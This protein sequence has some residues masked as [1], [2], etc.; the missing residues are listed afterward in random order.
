MDV[1]LPDGTIITNVPDGTTKADLQAKLALKGMKAD[2]ANFEQQN[3]VDPAQAALIGAGRTGDKA[4]AGAKQIGLSA[5]V[6][7]RDLVGADTKAPL[8]SLAMLDAIQKGNDTEYR[9]LQQQFP[10]ST[11]LGEAFPTLA[12]PMGQ[13]TTLGRVMAPAI[14]TGAIEAMQ[15]GSPLERFQR[16]VGGF[17]AGLTGGGIG[18][19]IG[20]V[21]QPVRQVGNTVAQDAAKAAAAKIGAPLL[22]SQQT[23]NPTLALIE[24]SLARAPGSAGVIGGVLR[25]QQSAVNSAAARAIQ[26]PGDAVTQSVVD[27]AMGNPAA[28]VTGA[29]P[30]QYDAFRAQIPNG[31]P[32]VSDVF[33][34]IDKGIASLSRGDRQAAGKPEAI[35]MLTRLKDQLYGTKALTPEDYSG[36]V[37]DLAAAARASQNP[38][39]AS[40]LKQVGGVMDTTARGPL[41]PAWRELDQAYAA[42]RTLQKS[43]AYNPETGDVLP[44]TLANYMRAHPSG[45]NATE[46]ADVAAFGKAVPQLRIG[47]PT[48]SRQEVGPIGLLNM[49]WRYPLAKALASDAMREYLAR[50]FLASPEASRRGAALVSRAL[51]PVG[52]APTMGLLSPLLSSYQ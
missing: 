34:A 10:I 4:L 42:G 18:E 31:M 19:G 24:D 32:A 35:A 22:P 6:I 7:G 25:K 40:V 38:V 46:L 43:K 51:V 47:S 16:G 30:V 3:I 29:L 49:A 13:A 27:A 17:A 11:R 33:D 39:T 1:R 20:R 36:W 37:S 9:K 8:Q 23:G 21:I 12:I 15:Y 41:N 50:G 52:M 5:D 45:A 48:F 26:Q 14:G 28:K 2:Y 44:V